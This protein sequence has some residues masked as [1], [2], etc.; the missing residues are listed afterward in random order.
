MKRLLT[1]ML[2]TLLLAGCAG[3]L[4]STATYTDPHRF[5][6]GVKLTM[7]NGAIPYRDGRFTGDRSGRFL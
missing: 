4:A 1:F 5:S 6:T 2:A 3:D 7:V